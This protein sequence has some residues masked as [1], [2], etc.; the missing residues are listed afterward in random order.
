MKEHKVTER[1]ACRVLGVNRTAYRYKP[2]KLPDEDEVCAAVIEK[3]CNYGRVGYRMVTNMLRTDG[4]HINHKRVERIWRPSLA[5]ILPR[6]AMIF[7]HR[8]KKPI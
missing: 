4:K 5:T 6:F 7:N 2:V 8:W 3:V 1:R